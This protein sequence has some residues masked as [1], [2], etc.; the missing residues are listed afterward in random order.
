VRMPG[1][2]SR[3]A[4][5]KDNEANTILDAWTGYKRTD[6]PPRIE[7]DEDGIFLYDAVQSC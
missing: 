3:A 7:R 1:A 2:T 6:S 5:Y 4:L